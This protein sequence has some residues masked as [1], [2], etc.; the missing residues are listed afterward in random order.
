[1]SSATPWYIKGILYV[2]LPAACIAALYLSIPGEIDLARSAGW[3]ERYAPAMPVCISVYALS[4]GAIATYRRKAE[5]PGQATALV[6]SLMSLLLAMAAQS[7]SHLIEQDYMVTSA[8][9]VVAVSCVPPLTIA[10]LVHMAE[11]PS[12]VKTASQEMEELREMNGALLSEF[13]SSESGALLSHTG[14][15]LAGL[16]KTLGEVDYLRG[17]AE[18]ETQALDEELDEAEKALTAKPRRKVLELTAEKIEQTRESIEA[19]GKKPTV[20]RVCAALGIS[21]ASYYRYREPVSA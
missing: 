21:Q 12:Q 9:L 14:W 13:V 4:A 20:E 1:M 18:R 6:G 16:G 17:W 11:T 15:T 10:H 3:S 2:A 7:I 8:A 19:G 5:L